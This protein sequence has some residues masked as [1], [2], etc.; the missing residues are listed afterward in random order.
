MSNHLDSQ[1]SPP[2][3]SNIALQEASQTTASPLSQYK[4]PDGI[5]KEKQRVE[6][7]EFRRQK[8]KLL[9]KA[10]KDADQRITAAMRLNDIQERLAA[11]EEQNAELREGYYGEDQKSPPLRLKCFGIDFG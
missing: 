2:G 8:L 10:T 9:E 7:S 6:E 3:D 5:K 1:F 4:R 11:T